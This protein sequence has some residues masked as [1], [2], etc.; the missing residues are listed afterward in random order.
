[1]ESAK[2]EE[3]V[4]EHGKKLT[5][6]SISTWPLALPDP[7]DIQQSLDCPSPI[8]T[9]GH[10]KLYHLYYAIEQLNCVSLPDSTRVSVSARSCCVAYL[11]QI[12]I[13]PHF[14]KSGP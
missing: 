1:M 11:L 5:Y 3:A 12:A 9:S 4:R 8:V 10:D 7:E 14:P 2:A 13:Y 6:L